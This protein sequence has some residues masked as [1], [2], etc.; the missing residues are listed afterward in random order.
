[1]SRYG[2]SRGGLSPF[3]STLGQTGIPSVT[4]EDFSYITSE[5]LETLDVPHGHSHRHHDTDQY[6]HSAPGPAPSFGHRKPADDVMLI[7]HEGVTYPEHF[8]AYSIGDGKLQVDDVMQRVQWVLGLTSREARG[9]RLFYKGH[10]LKEPRAPVRD[11]GVKNN[12]EVM[13]VRVEA[14]GGSSSGSSE[15]IVVVGREGRDDYDP[16]K[17]ARRG[18]RR[19][20]REEERSPRSSAPNVGLEVPTEDPNRRSVSRVRTQSPSSLSAVSAAS[21]SAAIPGGPIEKVN[22]IAV[23]FDTKL[24]PLCD[25]FLNNPPSDQKKREDEHR[26]LTE[27]VMA[28]VI[29]KLDAIEPAGEP[30]AR[31]RRKEFIKE[32][33]GILKKMDEVK[34]A[35]ASR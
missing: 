34:E 9:I 22:A 7:K 5:D 11:Y 26:K 24:R 27:T 32:V 25:K 3:G 12:S 18:N 28:Q 2:F 23:Q 17:K 14:V 19:G 21:A 6:S 15:E 20:R 29:L 30:G 4:E 10:Q 13:A 16:P 8:P 33:Q 35:R 1:M 31:E